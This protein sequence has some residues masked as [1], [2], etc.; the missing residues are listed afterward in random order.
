MCIRDSPPPPP[1][2]PPPGRN[3]GAGRVCPPPAVK[4]GQKAHLTTASGPAGQTWL[5]RT[6]RR[7]TGVGQT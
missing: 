6:G 4:A 5:P 1:P 3:L 7:P 2:P